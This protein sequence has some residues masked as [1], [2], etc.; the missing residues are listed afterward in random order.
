MTPN[1]EGRLL[2]LY[3]VNGRPDGML[4]AEVFGWT[5]HILKTPRTQIGDA[6]SRKE[7]RNTGVYIL[8]GEQRG[9]A[10]AYVGEG[11]NIGD[12]IRT[13]DT[14]KDWWTTAVLVTTTA[15]SLNKAHVKYLE[16]RLVEEARSAGRVQLGNANTPPRPSLSEGERSN[17]ETF[18]GFISMVLPALQI[19][20]FI[21]N[22]RPPPDPSLPRFTLTNQKQGLNAT[23]VLK[24][25]EFIVEEG[26]LARLHWISHHE[27]YA[28]LYEELRRTKVLREQG[29]HCVFTEN[30]AFKST[31][32]AAS[33]ING[34]PS[35][36]PH[37]WR[38]KDKPSLR[39]KDWEASQLRAKTTEAS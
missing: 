27:I 38:V 29:D 33:V 18:L 20:M 25:G 28:D 14:K 17:M 30:Y 21:K 15:N 37:L 7:A 36:G 1:A 3:F 5:L 32:A 8:L 24:D 39:Y 35:D 26:S 13:H 23:A 16:A 34:Y 12:R 31:S 9:K 22:T 2:E 10:F 11:E 19:D 4:T 6:L